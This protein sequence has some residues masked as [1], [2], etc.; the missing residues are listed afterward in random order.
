M[1]LLLMA[2][3]WIERP[4]KVHCQQLV[5]TQLMREITRGTA[6]DLRRPLLGCQEVIH[7][8]R[9]YAA[10]AGAA[11]IPYSAIINNNSL[12]DLNMLLTECATLSVMTNVN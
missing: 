10:A 12:P 4:V 6:G 9:N 8:T 2:V 1:R 5:V 7:Q 3:E 11:L